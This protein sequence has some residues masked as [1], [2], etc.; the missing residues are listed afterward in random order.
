MPSEL[1]ETARHFFGLQEKYIRRPSWSS[2][3]KTSKQVPNFSLPRTGL[4]AYLFHFPPVGGYEYKAINA[5][6][7]I[8]KAKIQDIIR[9][10]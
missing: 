1:N 7:F 4:L 3:K 5:A 10:Y 8:V 6:P 9:I 2:N